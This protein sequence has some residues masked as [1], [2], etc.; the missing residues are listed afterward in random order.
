[1]VGESDRIHAFVGDMED[2]VRNWRT[3]LLAMLLA[4][5][6]IP[7]VAGPVFAAGKHHAH[8]AGRHHKQRRGHRR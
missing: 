6:A 5:F 3:K 7:V 4:I 8:R 2:T 1:M